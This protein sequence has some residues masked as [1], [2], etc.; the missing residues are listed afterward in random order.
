MQTAYL[1]ILKVTIWTVALVGPLSL[2][3]QIRCSLRILLLTDKSHMW[4]VILH[5]TQ[6]GTRR[7]VDRME[8]ETVVDAGLMKQL[9]VA[10]LPLNEWPGLLLAFWQP[11]I[12]FDS[13]L[14]GFDPALA[15]EALDPRHGLAPVPQHILDLFLDAHVFD[16]FHNFAISFVLSTLVVIQVEGELITGLPW[17][18]VWGHLLCF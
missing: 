3:R 11:V 15:G 1:L 4:V 14:V 10:L 9:P 8:V 12:F 16:S 13:L 17:I 2:L 5:A 18:N 6:R 7:W